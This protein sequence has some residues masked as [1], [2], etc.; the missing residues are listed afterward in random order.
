MQYMTL[1]IRCLPCLLFSCVLSIADIWH[2]WL[3]PCLE[4]W[5][6][7]YNGLW[8]SGPWLFYSSNHPPGPLPDN[9]VL[10]QSALFMSIS[11]KC[12]PLTSLQNTYMCKNKVVGY[13]DC[14]R[15]SDLYYYTSRWRW[16]KAYYEYIAQVLGLSW[17]GALIPAFSRGVSPLCVKSTL[18]TRNF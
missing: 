12:V 2:P 9:A 11:F 17:H 16:V 7:W 15:P 3:L 18:F 13:A 5:R 8:C 6:Y 10:N 14:S 4:W 1:V